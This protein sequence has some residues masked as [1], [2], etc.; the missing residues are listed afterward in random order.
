MKKSAK[1]VISAFVFASS[2][3]VL[4][5]NNFDRDSANHALAES[6]KSINTTKEL[7]HNRIIN[8]IDNFKTATGS[9]TYMSKVSGANFT[10]DYAIRNNQNPASYKKITN[11]HNKSVKVQKNDGKAQVELDENKK[12]YV[13][14]DLNVLGNVKDK[15]VKNFSSR[16]I[17]NEKGEKVIKYRHDPTHMGVAGNS[18]FPQELGFSFL[19]N[20]SLWKITEQVNYLDLNAVVIEGTLDEYMSAKL[21]ADK[22]KLLVHESSGILLK[23][24]VF[25]SSNE[26]VVLSIDTHN[27][28]INGE[29]DNSKLSS[30][31]P[32]G[33]AKRELNRYKN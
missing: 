2:F 24:E 13:K 12:E 23:A 16:F 32:P 29:V 14:Y 7:I 27:I 20:Y 9:F 4:A 1:I 17:K 28:K 21:G 30:K 8:T 26:E 33:Y 15:E 25:N 6:D 22:F 5:L 11:N 18:I 3:G 31:E 19:N 10:V